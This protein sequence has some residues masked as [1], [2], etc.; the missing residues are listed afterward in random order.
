[1]AKYTTAIRTS[2]MS[3]RN[4]DIGNGAKI[5][6]YKG[7]T[8]TDA[9]TAL[10]S[11]TLVVE[12]VGASPFGAAANGVLTMSGAPLSANAAVA[13]A[14]ADNCF[15]RLFK[16]DG[17]TVV[18]DFTCATSGTEFIINNKNLA[19]GQQVQLTGATITAGNA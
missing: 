17:T 14:D 5:R 19:V 3:Q 9:N 18:G 15:I 12:W 10:G 13:M 16:A 2:Q 7:A 4:T 1:M 6:L 11:Q 8:P